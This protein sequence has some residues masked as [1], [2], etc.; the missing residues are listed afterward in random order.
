MILVLEILVQ[1][2]HMLG[3]IGIEC[4]GITKTKQKGDQRKSNSNMLA[5]LIHPIHELDS[6]SSDS[7][8][9]K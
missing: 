6:Y 2:L 1:D 7:V 3:K 5:L 4:I 9:P 8:I